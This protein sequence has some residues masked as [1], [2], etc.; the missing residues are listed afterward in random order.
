MWILDACVYCFSGNTWENKDFCLKNWEI[1][2][3][4]LLKGV[5]KSNLLYGGGR[6]KFFCNSPVRADYDAE[7]GL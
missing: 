1:Q 4:N 5:C 7:L 6:V 3:Y 2:G